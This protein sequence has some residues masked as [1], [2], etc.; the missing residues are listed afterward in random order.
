MFKSNSKYEILTPTGWQ[1]F[2]GVQLTKKLGVLHIQ[3][4]KNNLSCSL[5]HP[6]LT[7]RGFIEA[8]N[9]VV[10]DK[11]HDKNST[12]KVLMISYE[13]IPFEFYEAVEVSNGNQYYTNDVVSH[14]CQFMGSSGTLI[15]G[16]KLKQLVAEAKLNVPIFNHD[17]LYQFEMPIKDHNYVIVA[18]VSKG[19]GLDHS[20]FHVID[21][22]VTPYKQVATFKD[23]M[24]VPTDYATIIHNAATH[25]NNA[26]ILVENNAMGG[27]VI[28]MLWDV[29]GYENLFCTGSNGR[30]GKRLI[31]GYGGKSTD[32]GVM[33]TQPVRDKGCAML[34][35]LIEQNQLAVMDLRTVS[36]LTT[37]SKK[38]PTS[39]KYEAEEGKTDDMVMGLVLFG[40]MASQQ[41]FKDLTDKS[42]MD[43]IRDRTQ[44][45][46]ENSM[47]PM[48]LNDDG[49]DEEVVVQGHDVWAL[50]R[51]DY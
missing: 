31:E 37:F 13:E 10:G 14:N 39:I 6:I 22:S 36:E 42:V 23:N 21:A 2:K 43:L 47:L 41:L 12:Q 11:I 18:D 49:S 3:M 9:L 8:Q 34:K 33:T 27:E 15:A 7:N 40:W 30:A 16:W 24:I 51:I 19:K 4:E 25:Y 26:Y 28:N 48:G 20:A 35:L 17:K 5:N 38:T 45:E 1:D 50:G 46:I 44:Q 32:F 29:I